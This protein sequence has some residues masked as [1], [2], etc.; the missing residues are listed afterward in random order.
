[1]ENRT[2]KKIEKAQVFIQDGKRFRARILLNWA[3]VVDPRDESSKLLLQELRQK[4]SSQEKATELFTNCFT[5]EKIAFTEQLAK[6]WEFKI[7]FL[8]H[9]LM[10]KF[11]CRKISSLSRDA[12]KIIFLE[13]SHI[14]EETNERN[15]KIPL[16]YLNY[17]SVRSWYRKVRSFVDFLSLFTPLIGLVAF[18]SVLVWILAVFSVFDEATK[19]PGKQ[20]VIPKSGDYYLEVKSNSQTN[21]PYLL[22]I[23]A[24]KESVV[25]PNFNEIDVYSLAINE[26]VFSTI[27]YPQIHIY[28]FGPTNRSRVIVDVHRWF[29]D[30]DLIFSLFD[31]QMQLCGSTHIRYEK[32]FLGYG[33]LGCGEDVVGPYT[34]KIQLPS[35]YETLPSNFGAEYRYGFKVNYFTPLEEEELNNNPKNAQEIPNGV[36]LL[37]EINSS[38]SDWY[39][40]EG[41]EGETLVAYLRTEGKNEL[42]FSVYRDGVDSLEIVSESTPDFRLDPELFNRWGNTKYSQAIMITIFLELLELDIGIEEIR[43]WDYSIIAMFG[44]L[45]VIY[46]FILIYMIKV[47]HG[48]FISILRYEDTV[49]VSQM[50]EILKAMNHDNALQI[51]DDKNKI[52]RKV[53]F[54]ANRLR[55]LSDNFVESTSRISKKHF[56]NMASQIMQTANM[57]SIP[58]SDTLEELRNQF[59]NWLTIFLLGEYGN[60]QF[61]DDYEII[62]PNWKQRILI[63]FDQNGGKYII[64]FSIF[65]IV[66]TYIIQEQWQYVGAQILSWGWLA[67]RYIVLIISVYLIYDRWG[68]PVSVEEPKFRSVVKI[69]LFFIVPLVFFDALLQTGIIES[70][71]KILESLSL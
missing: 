53:K 19:L 17:H 62:H 59:T 39:Q 25:S 44:V 58:N 32:D 68:L 29:A 18:I 46:I 8:L 49:A 33:S 30:T 45:V 47:F 50:I 7:T 52:I 63:T 20:F 1:L 70:I 60:F 12:K 34:L 36:Y 43:D 2:P 23:S 61:R 13:F 4:Q 40:I 38:D 6:K 67:I 41:K 65:A 27:S 55:R 56:S 37:G 42:S 16:N 21:F 66:A 15:K 69:V 57:V 31:A 48:R 11:V 28:S 3:R 26:R 5:G 54:A 51:S 14:N 22:S 24:P 35:D 10:P 64:G 9:K 71:V